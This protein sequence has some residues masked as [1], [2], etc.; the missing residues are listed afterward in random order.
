MDDTYNPQTKYLARYYHRG[1]WFCTDFYADSWEDAEAICKSH[2]FVL[3][4]EHVMTIPAGG[5]SW[6]PNLIV[7]VR[8]ALRGI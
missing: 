8:N 4:G 2:S 1:K 5:G 6:L 3:D 7:R